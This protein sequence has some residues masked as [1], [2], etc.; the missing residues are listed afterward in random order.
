[1]K[2]RCIIDCN[3]E[4]GGGWESKTRCIIDCNYELGGGRE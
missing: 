4:L 3:Y 2:T 1:M